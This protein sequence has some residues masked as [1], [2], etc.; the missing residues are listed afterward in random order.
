MRR[1]SQEPMRATDDVRPTDPREGSVLHDPREL[2]A[3]GCR[4]L[5]SRGGLL[6]GALGENVLDLRDLPGGSATG[7]AFWIEGSATLTTV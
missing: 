6:G 7:R 5:S 3:L 1:R 4:Q 2:R